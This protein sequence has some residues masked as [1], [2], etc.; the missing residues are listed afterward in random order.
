M[1]PKQSKNYESFSTVIETRPD[2]VY[3]ILYKKIIVS[4]IY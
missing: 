2:M 4:L 1:P 3:N